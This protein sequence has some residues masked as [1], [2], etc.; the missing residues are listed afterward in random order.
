MV[1]RH[2][3]ALHSRQ[4]SSVLQAGYGRPFT[5]RLLRYSTCPAC[6]MGSRT[7]TS[8]LGWPVCWFVSAS[9]YP[10]NHQSGPLCQQAGARLGIPGLL[11]EAPSQRHAS[12]CIDS[13]L[14]ILNSNTFL[15]SHVLKIE[16][17]INTHGLSS[18]PFTGDHLVTL[19][20][21]HLSRFNDVDQ[22]GFTAQ[23]KAGIDPRL[24]V[25]RMEQITTDILESV[26]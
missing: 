1:S 10:N 15:Y 7:H 9:A 25:S 5:I 18:R 6:M 4:S 16:H 24:Q 26:R 14:C 11:Q 20:R 23:T 2:W 19:Y 13:S 17:S 3:L 21:G 8:H 22:M 12:A